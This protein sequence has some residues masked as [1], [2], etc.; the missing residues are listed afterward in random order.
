MVVGRHKK[1]LLYPASAD[2][3]VIRPCVSP[4]PAACMTVTQL[5]S[6]GRE[7]E[8]VH[9]KLSHVIR[10][11]RNCPLQTHFY[12]RVSYRKYHWLSFINSSRLYW[13]ITDLNLFWSP[14]KNSPG[15]FY[16]LRI[17]W[18]QNINTIIYVIMLFVSFCPAFNIEPIEPINQSVKKRFIH[19]KTPPTIGFSYSFI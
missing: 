17:S 14:N 2:S 10:I 8:R 13:L 3:T 16:V 6:R 11:F 18:R 9:L 12:S 5:G 1:Y 19:Y 15:R 4:H 7:V